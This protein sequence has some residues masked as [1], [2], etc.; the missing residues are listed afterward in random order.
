[1]I[2]VGPDGS[3]LARYRKLHLYEAFSQSEFEHTRAGEEL[4]PVFD[5]CRAR[6]KKLRV[7]LANCYDLPFS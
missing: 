3:E 1:M 2:A 4:P 7:G 6:G 5:A